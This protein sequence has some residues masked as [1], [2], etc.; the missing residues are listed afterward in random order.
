VKPVLLLFDLFFAHHLHLEFM[1]SVHLFGLYFFDLV[2][3]SLEESVSPNR[4][5]VFDIFQI[6]LHLCFEIDQKIE[7]FFV[8]VFGGEQLEQSHKEVL[9]IFQKRGSD[10]LNSGHFSEAH[11]AILVIQHVKQTTS[12]ISFNESIELIFIGHR[13]SAFY[14]RFVL[15]VANDQFCKVQ[16][17]VNFDFLCL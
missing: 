3:L 5:L 8:V 11:L 2:D 12:H 15:L 16:R 14:K 1:A 10:T 6:T 17:R 13:K 9:A 7:I 4:Q